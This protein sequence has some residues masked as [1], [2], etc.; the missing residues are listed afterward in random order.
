MRK[1]I[2]II[3]AIIVVFI[4]NQLFAQ[5]NTDSL[6]MV[7]IEQSRAEDYNSAI[8]NAKKVLEIHPDRADVAVFIANVYAWDRNYNLAKFYINTAY[9]LKPRSEILYDSWLN[10]VL[11]NAEY[12]QVL[13]TADIAEENKYPNRYNVLLKRLIAYKYLNQ[14]DAAADLFKDGKNKD[15]IDSTHIKSLA[16]E[17]ILKSKKHTATFYYSIDFFNNNDPKPQHLAYIDYSFRIKKNT[18]VFRLN[19]ANR[20]NENGLQLEADYYQLLKK[21]KYLYFNYGASIY[22]D[23]FPKHRAGA[24]FY[25]PLKRNFEASVGAR[26]LNFPDINVYTLTGHISKY[27]SYYWIAFRPYFSYQKNSNSISL[28]A[29]ARRYGKTTLSYWGIE[30]GYGNSPDE[31]YILDPSGDYFNLDS[32]RIKLEK[33]IM[34]GKADDLKV[35]FGFAYEET[36]KDQFRPRYTIEIIYKHR[37]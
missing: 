9:D 20:F 35:S 12:E 25:F 26:Y 5:T 4:A 21:S 37:L 7:A 28:V 19:Y 10:I 13:R 11:W 15:L 16:R 27:V 18:L 24:E 1:S 3:S 14:F 23:L 36:V 31:R 8:V 32:Y 22:N 30:L 6:F 33:N 29:N 2:H 34:I 17:L